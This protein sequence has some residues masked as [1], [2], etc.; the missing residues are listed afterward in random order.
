[1]RRVIAVV[2]AR[3]GSTRLPGKVLRDLGGR[4]VLAWVVGAA[5]ASEVCDEIVVATSSLPGDRR[6]VSLCEAEGFRCFA[7]SETDVL[8]RYY[9][10]A[11]AVGADHPITLLARTPGAGSLTPCAN[12]ARWNGLN[13]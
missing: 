12:Q 5:R 7:G 8:D 13:T 4:P 1:M 11:R 10:T 2:Q 6:V 9:E 3:T